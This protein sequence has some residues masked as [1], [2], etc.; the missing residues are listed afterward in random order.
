[1]GLLGLQNTQQ[2]RVTA[3]VEPPG[4]RIDGDPILEVLDPTLAIVGGV[5]VDVAPEMDQQRIAFDVVS[6]D[7]APNGLTDV[8]LTADRRLGE[9]QEMIEA[10]F[11]LAIVGPEATGFGFTFGEVSQKETAPPA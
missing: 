2:C 11:Q 9:Q 4:A 1:M 3:L 10:S 5:V 8:K 7:G 6:L